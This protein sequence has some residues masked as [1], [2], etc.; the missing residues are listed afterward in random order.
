MTKLHLSRTVVRPV[1]VMAAAIWLAGCAITA[2]HA[3][4]PAPDA[5][6]LQQVT[7]SVAAQATETRNGDRWWQD[8]SDPQLAALVNQALAN[9]HDLSAT[10]LRLEAELARLQVSRDQ[11]R[12][13]GG[14][15]GS[16]EMSRQQGSSGL[17]VSRQERAAAGLAASG[18]WIC[19]AGSVRVSVRLRP[20]LK[21]SR[22][23][24]RRVWLMWSAGWWIPT[25]A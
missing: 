2:Q 10:A 1:S 21:I 7:G 15:S 17:E 20:A 19:L 8:F 5:R 23:C 18:S 13:Q 11:R 22:L 3:P 25:S 4:L 12:P 6:A 16:L 14:V 9:N 24:V